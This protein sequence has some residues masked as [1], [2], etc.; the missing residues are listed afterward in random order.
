MRVWIDCTAAAHPL[1]L[2]PIAER[3][4]AAGHGPVDRAGVGQL[5]GILERLGIEHTVVGAH[6]G[7]RISAKGRAVP[8]AAPGCG[9]GR[10][11]GGS[12]SRSLTAR[13]T[14][15]WSPARFGSPWFR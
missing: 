7:A 13:L 10:A 14:S 4:V 11:E 9:G 12:T 8:G 15:R 6:A 5:V 2:R 3:I 1:V